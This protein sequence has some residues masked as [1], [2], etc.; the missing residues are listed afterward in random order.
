MGHG[1]EAAVDMASYRSDLRSLAAADLPPHRILRRLDDIAAREPDRRPATCL[2]ARVDPVRGRVTLSGAGH[3]PPVVV[4]GDGRTSPLPVPVG[5]PLGTGI[6]GYEP[7]THDLDESQTLLMF[8]DGLVER[9]GEDIDVS[10]DRLA[11]IRFSPG[12]GLDDIL[13]TVLARLG[14]LHAEDDVAVLAARP[15]STGAR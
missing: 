2:V 6:G 11:R 9:R 5:P 3:L 14:A 12:D 8:T 7:A 1:V 10:L 15:R 4:G 13:E